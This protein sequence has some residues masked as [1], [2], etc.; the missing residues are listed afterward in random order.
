MQIKDKTQTV[1][2]F[3]VANIKYNKNINNNTKK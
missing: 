3:K 1:P 2:P